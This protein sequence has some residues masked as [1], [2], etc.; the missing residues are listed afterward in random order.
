[1]ETCMEDAIFVFT[2]DT[3][4]LLA[5]RRLQAMA[6]TVAYLVLSYLMYIVYL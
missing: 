5:A 1:M 2:W 4:S 6:N 3:A